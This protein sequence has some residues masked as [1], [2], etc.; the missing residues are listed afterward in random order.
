[1]FTKYFA[2]GIGIGKGFFDDNNEEKQMKFNKNGSWTMGL[3]GVYTFCQKGQHG[4]G[5]STGIEQGIG[6]PIL[7]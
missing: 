3:I 4:F 2:M 5:I 1:M 6:K 7:I